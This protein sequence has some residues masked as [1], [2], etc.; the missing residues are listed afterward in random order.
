MTAGI[1]IAVCIACGRAFFPGRVLCPRCGGSAWR[2]EQAEEGVVEQATTVHHAIGAAGE[3]PVS[4]AS[5][6]L[7]LGPV[8]IVRLDGEAHAGARVTLAAVDGAPVARPTR[9]R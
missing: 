5:V 3:A 6:R 7:T 4:L 8:V 1:T 2:A 9:S